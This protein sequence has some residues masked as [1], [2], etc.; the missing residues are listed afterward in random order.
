MNRTSKKTLIP[1]ALCYD[2]DGTL[3]PGNMQ[4]RSFLPDLGMTAE[5]FW[6]AC[7]NHAKE[8]DMDAI[9][10]YMFLMLREAGIR[11]KPINR[12]AFS[13]HGK[14][15]KFFPGVK[16]WFSRIDEYGISLGLDVQHFLISSGIREMVEGSSIAKHFRYIFASSFQYDENGVAI[17]PAL[18]V[19]YTN[20]TQ[21]LFRINKGIL[22]A[23]DNSKIN[24]YTPD[25]ERAI[26]FENFIYIG[27]GE[28]DVPAMK[29]LRFQGG[30][31]I[32]V[33]P[34]DDKSL[35]KKIQKAMRENTLDLIRRERADYVTGA[36]YRS[37][38]PL[39]QIVKNRMQVIASSEACDRLSSN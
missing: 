16:N 29:L 30:T 37:G 8:H 33:F 24:K 28:T 2:F 15:I 21:Y 20:K 36:D 14:S 22:N 39:D 35:S 34:P 7:E 1:V 17:W 31:A 10:G 13:N 4:E 32:G 3:A 25:E 26:P 38:K 11:K 27:D 5:E 19:N 23:W 6:T 12:K 18:A 9:L